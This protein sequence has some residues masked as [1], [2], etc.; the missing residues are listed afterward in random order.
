MRARGRSLASVKRDLL[1]ARKRDFTFASGRI[2][3]SMCTQPHQLALWT[4]DLF[5]ETNLGDPDH[6]PGCADLEERARGHIADLV[7]APE[8]RGSLFVSGGTEANI[9]AL[10]L[11]RTLT[12]KRVVVLPEHAHFSFEKAAK[13][14]DMELRY[15]PLDRD[16]RVDVAAAKDA[17]DDRT[18]MIVGV[19]GTTELGAVDD[20]A[21]LSDLAQR[22]NVMLHVDAAFGGFVLPFMERL[23]MPV[24]PWDF[25]LPGVDTLTIDPHK[26]GQS[27]IP[28]GT[29]VVRKKQWLDRIAVHTPYVS[30]GFQ[31]TILGTRPGGS[32]AASWAVMEHLGL[33]GYAKMVK[34]MFEVTAV[35]RAE[36]DR[37]GL[38]V[39]PGGELP[40]LVVRCASPE[41]VQDE[42]TR[43]GWRVNVTP[44]WNGVRLVLGPH[45]TKATVKKFVPALAKVVRKA[46]G[47]VSDRGRK[48]SM[49]GAR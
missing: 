16:T 37:H 27:T 7:H 34:G 26:M 20:L 35:L 22:R 31:S 45:V 8:G 17:V 1:Q 28:G 39:A 49:A 30:A 2:L 5:L 14:L 11:A 9:L 15:V 3:G 44:R 13:L 43:L 40:L 25:R 46:G 18:A 47:P 32:A 24:R 36:L 48:V 4:H 41:R 12:G 29:F 19:A 33:E 6:F 23:G 10:H 38:E 21:A 42:L